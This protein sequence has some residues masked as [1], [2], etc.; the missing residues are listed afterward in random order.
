MGC[1]SIVGR[2]LL[3]KAKLFL[4]STVEFNTV[5]YAI[6]SGALP[7]LGIPSYGDVDLSSRH[8]RLGGLLRTTGWNGGLGQRALRFSA[9]GASA[10]VVADLSIGKVAVVHWAEVGPG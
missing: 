7:I 4:N 6:E 10:G 5:S 1:D 9:E 3:L 2:G 8:N